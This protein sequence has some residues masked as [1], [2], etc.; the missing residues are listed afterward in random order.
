MGAFKQLHDIATKVMEEQQAKQ[1]DN[2][3]IATQNVAPEDPFDKTERLLDIAFKNKLIS[4]EDYT[5]SLVDVRE[6]RNRR[7]DAK[8]Q[9]DDFVGSLTETERNDYDLY[10]RLQ[11]G[12]YTKNDKEKDTIDMMRDGMAAGVY[13]KEGRDPIRY[14]NNFYRDSPVE[15]A[16]RI[17]VGK[18]FYSAIGAMATNMGVS[19]QELGIKTNGNDKSFT[20]PKDKKSFAKF[21][22][23]Y[24][25]AYNAYATTG[26]LTN[27][28]DEF[29]LGSRAGL[30]N[31]LVNFGGVMNDSKKKYDDII[32]NNSNTHMEFELQGLME[33]DITE[34][35]IKQAHLE[36]RIDDKTAKAALAYNKEDMIKHLTGNLVNYEVY[37]NIEGI[38]NTNPNQGAEGRWGKLS[39]IDDSGVSGRGIIQ[40]HLR[41][42]INSK[43]GGNKLEGLTTQF[44]YV[45]GV[46]YGT[47][48]DVPAWKDDKIGTTHGSYS[49]FVKQLMPSEA[50]DKF[51]NSPENVAKSNLDIWQSIGNI[52]QKHSVNLGI[53]GYDGKISTDGNRFYYTIGNDYEISKQ[54]AANLLA[55]S[56]YF[57][58]S[59]EQRYVLGKMLQ[60]AEDSEQIEAYQKQIDLYDTNINNWLTTAGDNPEESLVNTLYRATGINPSLIHQN[61][62]NAYKSFAQ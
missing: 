55:G 31:Q 10:H 53:S 61:L 19:L 60:N 8:S 38:T 59:C 32:N 57:R 56:E 4:S 52:N 54:E 36:G 12:E 47:I 3:V 33:G 44:T 2:T 39:K 9:Y 24:T 29:S 41:T 14:F 7:D 16:Q 18:D 58:R 11:N 62:Y 34:E 51:A 25:N 23:V 46:G 13:T 6:S 21:A 45:P 5:R 49:I 20:I 50:A 17:K 22:E 42:F 37:G 48:I 26:W 1:T 40:E 28:A 27:T 35:Y 43:T 15:G 30:H